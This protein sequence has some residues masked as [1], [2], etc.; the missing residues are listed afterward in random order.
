MFPDFVGAKD[1]RQRW[2]LVLTIG[3]KDNRSGPK[4]FG[5]HPFVN[6]A[7]VNKRGKEIRSGAR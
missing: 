1:V 3:G 5:R 6:G 7:A 4:R 2:E